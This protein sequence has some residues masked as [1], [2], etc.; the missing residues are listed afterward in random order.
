MDITRT[1]E[2][3]QQTADAIQDL[4]AYHP[5]D[6]DQKARGDEIRN[7]LAAALTKIIE[8]VPPCPD[9]SAAIRKLREARMDAMSAITHR[10]KY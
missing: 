3:D 4:F 9:R 8:H 5:L 10:G 7:A 2:V 6:Q 1:S